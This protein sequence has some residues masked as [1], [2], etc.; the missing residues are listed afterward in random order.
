LLASTSTSLVQAPFDDPHS[1]HIG[2]SHK[3]QKPKA[4]YMFEIERSIEKS[5]GKEDSQITCHI[6]K[7]LEELAIE[8][9]SLAIADSENS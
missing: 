5:I 7:W 6:A 8:P 9:K 2:D 1:T 3:L 4:K